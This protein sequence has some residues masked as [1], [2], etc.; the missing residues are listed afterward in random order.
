M[1]QGLRMIAMVLIP[2]VLGPFIGAAVIVGANETYV[3]LGVVKQV[4]TPWIFAAAAIVAALTVL[5]MAAL[6]RLPA[7][8]PEPLAEV[9][10]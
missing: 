1:V 5:P 10:A 8:A 7:A 9:E 3:D 4:P 2:M 6:R